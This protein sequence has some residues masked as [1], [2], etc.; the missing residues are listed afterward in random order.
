MLSHI[1]VWK[2]EW[3][4]FSACVVQTPKS[5]PSLVQVTKAALQAITD[6]IEKLV[7]LTVDPA[8]SDYAVVTGVQIHSGNQVSC[9]NSC[10]PSCSATPST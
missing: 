4:P 1:E 6:D 5:D 8:T 9:N 7:S 3:S 2:V 10:S